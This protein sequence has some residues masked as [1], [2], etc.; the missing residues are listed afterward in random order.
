MKY[1]A[2]M[3]QFHG[4]IVAAV[5]LMCGKDTVARSNSEGASPA[6]LRDYLKKQY[7]YNGKCSNGVMYQNIPSKGMEISLDREVDNNGD[8]FIMLSWSQVAKFIRDNPSEIFGE[9]NKPGNAENSPSI[10]ALE[11]DVTAFNALKRAGINTIEDIENNMEELENL[12]PKK[13]GAVKDKIS[14]YYGIP[15]PGTWAEEDMLG[16]ELT[17]D[18]IT[19]MVG[20]IIIIDQSTES[21]AW[22]KAARVER[23]ACCENGDRR[24]F[25]FDGTKQRGVISEMYF[26][27]SRGKHQRAWRVKQKNTIP[28]ES[29]AE[30]APAQTETAVVFDYSELDT[31]TAEQLGK[32]SENVLNIKKKYIFDMAEQVKKAHDLLANC[33]NGLFGAWCMSIG[34]SRDTGNNLVN[35]AETFGNISAEEQK[36][37]SQLKPSLLYEAAR[38]SAPPELVEAVK[39]GD[40]TTHKEYI[41]LKKQLEEAESRNRLFNESF[42]DIEAASKANYEKYLEELHKNQDLQVQIRK[43]E[44]RPVEVAVDVD[45]LNRRVEKVSIELQNQ[46]ARQIAAEREDFAQK[47]NRMEDENDE[48]RA[49]LEKAKAAKTNDNVKTVLLRMT[50]DEL[51]ELAEVVPAGKFKTIIKKAQVLRV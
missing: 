10:E 1:D 27:E 41:A 2:G 20:E 17:F 48:L 35:I 15:I 34:I 37:L 38:P 4:D 24:L 3:T 26:D 30:I 32:I 40:I 22:Y 7:G 31:D 12:I 33:K 19:N 25:Y 13:I 44:S 47:L 16:D 36:N 14:E 39:N 9:E 8:N 51:A 23:I 42:K 18:E 29:S 43:L 45:E 21:H 49:E 46:T 11:L 6:P 50:L 28:Q 5:R